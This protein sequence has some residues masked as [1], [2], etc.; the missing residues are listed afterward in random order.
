M[1]D[2]DAVSGRAAGLDARVLR[3]AYACF[4]SGVVS[5][6]GLVN[7]E[8][9][10]LVA[11]SFTT[12]SI[13]PPLVSFCIQNDS[14]TWPRLQPLPRLG[15][16]VLGEA[17]DAACR[18]MSAKAGDRFA[19]LVFETTPEGAIFID[20]APAWIECSIEDELPA[21]DHRIVLLRVLALTVSP[22]VA[23]LVFHG[24]RFA[25]LRQL[26]A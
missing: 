25:S 16:S 18:Q 14:T 23:P 11:S 3:Q 17:H 13:D 1:T 15:L 20:G 6:C 10:G 12:V 19:G 8:P 22:A 26:A 2:P 7:T 5:I 9:V 21:G 24:S 4:P